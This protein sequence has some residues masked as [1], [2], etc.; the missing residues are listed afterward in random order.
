[1][2]WMGENIQNFCRRFLLQEVLVFCLTNPQRII[3]KSKLF[4]TIRCY[5]ID[6]EVQF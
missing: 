2:I 6:S 1:M 3:E 4:L 5:A